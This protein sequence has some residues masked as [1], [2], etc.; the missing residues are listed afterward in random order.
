MLNTGSVKRM[1]E[2][3][4]I[5]RESWESEPEAAPIRDAEAMYAAIRQRLAAVASELRSAAE[6]AGPSGKTLLALADR[7]EQHAMGGEAQ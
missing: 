1:N 2:A 3:G 5:C 6:A 7:F 4:E